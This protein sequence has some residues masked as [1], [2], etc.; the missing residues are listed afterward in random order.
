ME[1]GPKQ[2]KKLPLP[3]QPA[4][5]AP[6]DRDHDGTPDATDRCPDV[7]GPKDNFGCPLPE[8]TP[9]VA[10]A[11]ER[12]EVQ[13]KVQFNWDSAVIRNDQMVILNEAAKTLL[14]LLPP[15]QQKGYK[16]KVEGHAS[17]EGQVEYNNKLSQRRAD[18]VVAY[19]VSLGV[20]AENITATGFGSRVPVAD[21][22]TEAGRIA[23]RRVEFVVNFVL[24]KE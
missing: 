18:A 23:N 5:Q 4:P 1:I 8:P 17:S 12:V 22:K 7:P 16:I 6:S 21:N 19:L 10:P 15:Q 24:V 3:K 9:P 20:P 13:G 14:V 11:P 2:H